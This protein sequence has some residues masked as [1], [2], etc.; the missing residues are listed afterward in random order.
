[1]SDNPFQEAYLKARRHLGRNDAV[2]KSI[3]T[4]IGKITLQPNPDRFGCLVYSIVAQQI[5][6]RAA[7]AIA[8]RLKQRVPLLD[9]ASLL[10]S[11]EE[12]LRGAGL[13]S[14]KASS[15]RDLARCVE[16]GNVP[17]DKLDQWDDEQVI[18]NLTQVKGIGRWTAEMFLIFGLGRLD[19][20]PVADFGLR[21]ALNRYYG[22][23]LS[24]N[25]EEYARLGEQWR[26]Y[27]TVATWYLWR[28]SRGR[29]TKLTKQ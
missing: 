5:S 9:P 16:N 21:S 10:R 7:A 11:S 18:A 25:R 1:M 12:E 15:V 4:R 26:P 14:A 29:A 22:V 27:R 17:L 6:T 19:V 20:F 13:S 28:Q 2:L 23:S 8:E 24:A 3:M